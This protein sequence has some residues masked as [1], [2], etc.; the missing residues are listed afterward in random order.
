MAE[1]KLVRWRASV[2]KGVN[3]ISPYF[4]VCPIL[5]KNSVHW[6]FTEKLSHNSIA[7]L[8]AANR[9]LVRV[10]N[11]CLS[12]RFTVIVRCGY[13]NIWWWPE[14]LFLPNQRRECRNSPTYCT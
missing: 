14:P 5:D 1:K 11:V 10:V 13:N 2:M 4:C 9:P 3:E 8:C 7:K 6:M 12:V